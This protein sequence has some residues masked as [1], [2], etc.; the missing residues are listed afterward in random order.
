MAGG[1]LGVKLYARSGAIL[2]DCRRNYWRAKVLFTLALIQSR[3]A[4]LNN[5]FDFTVTNGPVGS[6]TGA[7]GQNQPAAAATLSAMRCSGTAYQHDHRKPV[8]G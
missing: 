3:G 1:G 5:H 6:Y 2:R 7:H 4:L 8:S